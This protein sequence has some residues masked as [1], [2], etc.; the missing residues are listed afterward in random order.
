MEPIT[1]TTGRL[2]LRA[3]TEDDTDEVFRLCQDPQVQRWTCVPS[4]YERRHARE[5]TGETVPEGWR[6]STTP[7]FALVPPDGGPLMGSVS[8]T[9]RTLSGTWE[10]GYWLGAE[11]RGRGLMTEAVTE[12]AHWSFGRLGATRLEWRA[13][14]GNT[15]SRAV[16][17]RAGFTPE[18]TLRAAINNNG[19]LRD[20]WVGSLLPSDLGLSGT[21]AYLPARP[22]TSSGTGGPGHP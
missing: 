2:L 21:Y 18:G 13:E 5:F 9:L 22:D 3:F 4:P 7:T 17:L 1:L 14:V 16:A 15:A 6:T 10:V 8:V 20:A 19:T 11:Y 12:I